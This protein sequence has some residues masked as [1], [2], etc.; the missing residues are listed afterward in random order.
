MIQGSGKTPKRV[1]ALSAVLLVC[2]LA[3]S[4]LLTAQVAEAS[5]QPGALAA[6]STLNIYQPPEFFANPNINIAP[7]ESPPR[8]ER[9]DRPQYQEFKQRLSEERGIDYLLAY[10]PLFQVGEGGRD[11]IDAELD[12]GFI[13][14]VFDN[15]H[16]K[17]N[18]LTY[19]LWVQTYSTNPTGEFAQPYGVVTQPNSGGTDPNAGTVQLNL[20]AWEQTWLDESVSFRFGQLRNDFF[21]GTNKYHNDD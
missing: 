16:S 15:G 2:L 14:N 19:M 6:T 4:K 10:T 1:Q 13:W 5:P 3:H 21:F 17:G 18:L 11:Y 20:F 12:F 8:I 7:L 9:F